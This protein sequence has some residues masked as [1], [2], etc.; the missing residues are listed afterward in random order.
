M[1]GGFDFA[2]TITTLVI[3]IGGRDINMAIGPL[4]DDVSLRVLYNVV[5]TIVTQS[6]TSVEMWVAM[7]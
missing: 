5:E 2:G 4:F 7:G 1:T 3:E 6:I